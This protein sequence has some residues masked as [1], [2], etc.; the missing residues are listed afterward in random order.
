MPIF[1][2]NEEDEGLVFTLQIMFITP[3]FVIKLLSH[4]L[5]YCTFKKIW[6]LYKI[7][8]ENV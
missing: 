4:K 2:G 3:S 8:N 5:L 6:Q 1:I 7:K